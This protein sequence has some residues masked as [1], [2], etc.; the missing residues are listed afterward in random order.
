MIWVEWGYDLF[1]GR[2][3]DPRNNLRKSM[4][5]RERKRSAN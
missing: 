1:G 4:E 2:A 3:K 5:M